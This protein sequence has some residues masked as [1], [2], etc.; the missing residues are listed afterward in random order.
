MAG[1][2][3]KDMDTMNDTPPIASRFEDELQ[4][5]GGAEIENQTETGII[6]SEKEIHL[7][8]SCYR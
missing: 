4:Q 5:A 8:S 1:F 3:R 6:S 2:R 7:K